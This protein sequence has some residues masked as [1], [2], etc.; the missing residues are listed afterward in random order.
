MNW[1]KYSQDPLVLWHA[2]IPEITE[3]T[4]GHGKISPSPINFGEKPGIYLSKYPNNAINHAFEELQ[5]IWART[6]NLDD[7]YNYGFL[8]LFKVL[9]SNTDNLERIGLSEYLYN[10]NIYD[11]HNPDARF[12]DTPQRI[13]KLRELEEY[14]NNRDETTNERIEKR[15]NNYQN[16]LAK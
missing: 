1:Y 16:S 2:T 8:N 5:K 4:E 13:S 9:I 14:V 12:G 10:T 11:K 7:K 3:E 15:R 6:P